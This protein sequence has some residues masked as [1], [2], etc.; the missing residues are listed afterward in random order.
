MAKKS[1][2]TTVY[3]TKNKINLERKG[4]IRG[5]NGD[6]VTKIKIYNRCRAMTHAVGRQSFTSAV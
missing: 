2:E 4:N 3:F 5:Y 6:S 1:E